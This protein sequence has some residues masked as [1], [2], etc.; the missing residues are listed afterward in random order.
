LVSSGSF[1][2]IPRKQNV[3]VVAIIIPNFAIVTSIAFELVQQ[4]LCLE[5]LPQ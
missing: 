1:N 5:P 2:H 3:I 4:G